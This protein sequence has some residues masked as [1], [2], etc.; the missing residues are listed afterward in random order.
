MY[1]TLSADEHY[2]LSEVETAHQ[3]VSYVHPGFLGGGAV[4][5]SWIRFGIGGIEKTE[6]D[7]YGELVRIG[8]FENKED[9]FI[10]SY[11]KDLFE[12]M[13]YLGVNLKYLTHQLDIHSGQGYG[14]DVGVLADVS[15]IFDKKGR[16]MLGI[17][18][19]VKLGLVVRN[20]FEKLWDSGHRDSDSI[21]GD[22]GLAFDPMV[23]KSY[24]WTIA[25]ALC[26]T[27]EQPINSSLGTELQFFKIP[28]IDMLAVRAG[29]DDW[30]I[31]NRYEELS[32]EKLNYRR[33]LAAGGGLKIGIF[34]IDYTAVFERFGVKHR[35]SAALKF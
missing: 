10:I 21:S 14:V 6:M 1:T 23:S 24:K 27:K 2:T 7:Q 11:G 8:E 26:Q 22:L 17:L 34:Q 25:F 13:F 32:L 4:G 3:Y 29:V 9:A 20:N 35:M 19:N 15:S 30:Y 12:E 31:E 16:P 5:I 18:N 28:H 33:K